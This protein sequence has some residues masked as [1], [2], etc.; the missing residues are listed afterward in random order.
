MSFFFSP[1]D[2]DSE[3]LVQSGSQVFTFMLSLPPSFSLFDVFALKFANLSFLF[4]AR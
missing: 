3:A 4:A 2:L 1:A